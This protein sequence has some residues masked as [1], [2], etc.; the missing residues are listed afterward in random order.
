MIPIN[1]A[2]SEPTE[3]VLQSIINR[4]FPLSKRAYLQYNSSETK[5]DTISLS[6]TKIGITGIGFENENINIEETLSVDELNLL[7]DDVEINEAFSFLLKPSLLED[8]VSV[9]E[10]MWGVEHDT[11]SI[12]TA[13]DMNTGTYYRTLLQ[14]WQGSP[15]IGINPAINDTGSLLGA[16]ARNDGGRVHCGTMMNWQNVQDF[17]TDYAYAVFDNANVGTKRCDWITTWAYNAGIPSDAQVIGWK[18]GVRSSMNYNGA[19]NLI[20]RVRRGSDSAYVD[21]TLTIP[22]GYSGDFV[23]AY[24]NNNFN[25]NM[26]GIDYW[27]MNGLNI[28]ASDVNG[29]IAVSAYAEAPSPNPYTIKFEYFYLEVFYLWNSGLYTT[30]VFSKPSNG[31]WT[32]VAIGSWGNAST[33]IYDANTNALIEGGLVGS[34]TYD[35]SWITN[36]NIYLQ[37]WFSS[38]GAGGISS[39]WLYTDKNI[40]I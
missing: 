3:D 31:T 14:Y 9:N 27:S 37:T 18:V 15:Y 33:A 7:G 16:S 20:V 34:T 10:S 5:R 22:A 24:I 4:T 12:Q 17:D 26:A 36:Q 25:D 39:Y 13:A 30:K 32:S 29:N 21:H 6:D 2:Y 19:R 23:T 35:I 1:I 40:T 8:H 11:Q 28:T 38:A